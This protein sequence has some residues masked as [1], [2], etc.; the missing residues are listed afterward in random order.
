MNAVARQRG[1]GWVARYG[2]IIS[3]EWFFPKALQAIDEDPRVWKA[4]DVYIEAGEWLVW[5]LTGNLISSTCHGGYKQCWHKREGYPSAAYL[6]AVHKELPKLVGGEGRRPRVAPGRR[7]ARHARRAK[8][9]SPAAA[10]PS[11]ARSTTR[12]ARV[13]ARSNIPART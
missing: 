1:E 3:S 8:K 13:P 4:E 2:G 10:L 11:R 5:Q 6:K 7:P 9:P 12:T